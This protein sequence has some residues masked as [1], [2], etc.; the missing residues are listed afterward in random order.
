MIL[1]SNEIRRTS[2]VGQKTLNLKRLQEAG[3]K[4]PPF[5]AI[6]TSVVRKIINARGIIK[7]G[8]ITEVLNEIAEA[9]PFASYA[10]RSSALLED[11]RSESLAGQFKTRINI[12]PTELFQA[13]SEVLTQARI[14]LKGDIDKFSIIVQQYIEPTWSGVTFTRD[15]QGARQMIVE[16]YHGRGE[17]VVEGKVKPE[18]VEIYNG[19]ILPN[20]SLPQFAEA[21][22]EFKKVEQLYN[23]PQDIEWCVDGDE[24]Y[25]LQTRP[26]TSLTEMQYKQNIFL[27]QSL[28]AHKLFYFKKTE[29]TEAVPRPTALMLD[30]LKKLYG[31]NGPVERVYKKYGITYRPQDFLVV[32]GNE[33]Y[34]D[35]EKELHTLLPAYSFLRSDDLQPK[36]R[37]FRRLFVSLKNSFYLQRI[38]LKNYEEFFKEIKRRL[39]NSIR[40]SSVNG[41]VEFL[42]DNYEFVFEINLL[43]GVALKRMELMIKSEPISLAQLF[44][45]GIV[46]FSETN[47]QTI[48]ASSRRWVGNS[49]DI[50]DESVFIKQNTL[51]LEKEG[52]VELWWQAL[53]SLR[54]N[55]LLPFIK[56]ALFYNR[57]REYGRWLTVKS[58]HQLRKNLLTLAKRQ[59]FKNYK[60]IYFSKLEEVLEKNISE[61][62]CKKRASEYYEYNSFNFPII[63]T[64]ISFRDN[65]IP[66]G[67]AMGNARGVLI[68]REG[69][70]NNQTSDGA[71]VLY[72]KVL[73]PDLTKYF[74]R[75]KGIVSESGGV[76]SH[77]A[78]VARE[79]GMPVVVNA[80]L[81]Q[82]G[83]KLGEIVE[84]NG[85]SGEIKTIKP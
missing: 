65:K 57:L 64:N 83:L 55:T 53:P 11:S 46:F 45:A 27:D 16:Y 74:D 33:L 58:V 2:L 72:T 5:I 80:S 82:G 10:V 75:I 36:L 79:K 63:L 69:L 59:N 26:I 22:M 77:L 37:Y 52:A 50:A 66:Q 84:I 20:T 54:K 32:V 71:F 6:P 35:R 81:D 4:V 42:I 1:L 68:S 13:I 14:F 51:F 19:G 7:A 67:V 12:K 70:E 29:V 3:F 48:E 49:L 8:V 28:P 40:E 76:L 38:S 47:N 9:L 61:E 30:I 78:I 24:W 34:C 60:T 17:R 56:Q 85:G 44:R 73:S 39:E 15:P 25:F 23:L 18:R 62:I 31:I 21:I 41:S 43:A